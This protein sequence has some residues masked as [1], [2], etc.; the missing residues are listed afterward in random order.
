VVGSSLRTDGGET[1]SSEIHGP[2]GDV[3]VLRS[4][5]EPA[6]GEALPVQDPALIERLLWTLLD[7]PGNRE[8]LRDAA[9]ADPS[10]PH[11]PRSDHELV[12]LLARRIADGYLRLMGPGTDDGEVR[13]RG[14]VGG[15][16]TEARAEESE[17]EDVEDEV[18]IK[19]W[20]LECAHH[21]AAG[22]DLFEKGTRIELVPDEGSTADT[23]KIHWRDDWQASMPGQLEVR[24]PGRPAG[25]A[26]QNG[27]YPGGYT[28]YELEAEYLGDI[29]ISNVI[30]PGFWRAYRERTTHTVRPGPT[31]IPVEVYNPRRFRFEFSLPPMAGFKGGTKYEAEGS[32]E[33]R[34]LART[35]RVKKQVTTEDAYWSPSSKTLE[36]H[37]TDT[38]AGPDFQPHAS[39]Q[40]LVDTITITRDGQTIPELQ[41]L[42]FVGKVLKY[43]DTLRE[44]IEMV[45]DYA[46]K[47]GWYIDWNLQLMQGGLSVDWYWKEHTDHRVYQF[48]DYAMNLTIFSL[49]FEIGI[50]VSAVSFKLQIYAALSGELGVE[51]GFKRDSPDGA[52]GFRLPGVQGKITGVLG[53]RAE[54]GYVFKFDAKGETAIEAEA[55]IGINQRDAMVS[56]DARARWTGITCTCTVSAGALGIS[57]TKTETWELVPAGPWWGL[58]WPDD[59]PYE[60]PTMSRSAIARE[61]EQVLRRGWDLLV[62]E[63]DKSARYSHRAIANYIAGYVERDTAFDKVPK[64]VDALANAVRADLNE[65]ADRGFW[66]RDWLAVSDLRRYCRGSVRGKSLQPHLEAAASPTRQLI[67]ANQ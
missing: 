44:I 5:L 7:A 30:T 51:S 33:I 53:A 31:S 28:T 27:S 35:G 24:T 21:A 43:A 1:L 67:A 52:P 50:G 62:Y 12:R 38:D 19:D 64:A 17:P 22:R 56:V 55:Q 48:I 9:F 13:A 41:W 49:G 26:R 18:K 10:M 37:R 45:R 58:E 47:V 20:I 8:V 65:L 6:T 61:I 3:M 39:E 54:A 4:G 32:R 2:F 66:N 16:A 34:S 42:T 59:Q 36:T 15:G 25:T 46:P 11:V 57:W 14:V 29:D 60:P 40:K 63:D 23:V